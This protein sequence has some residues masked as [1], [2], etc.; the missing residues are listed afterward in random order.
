MSKLFT[1]HFWKDTTE[2]AISTA[3]QAAI[4][5]VGAD[6]INIVSVDWLEVAGFAA[7]G[8]VLTVL[9]ALAVGAKDGSPSAVNAPQPEP[10]DLVN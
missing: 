7:G 4:L 3:A 2:R 8:A 6:A 9:K 1:R 10:R 5:V